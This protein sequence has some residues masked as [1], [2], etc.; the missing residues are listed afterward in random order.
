V[1]LEGLQIAMLRRELL[2]GAAAGVLVLPLSER[3]YA[4]VPLGG[5]DCILFAKPTTE[6]PRIE[7]YGVM[8]GGEWHPLPE[9]ARSWA[10]C[11]M[12]ADGPPNRD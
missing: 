11:Y 4:D 12:I 3:Y 8:M 9:P 2:K 5:G 6:W 7:T 10:A 1:D